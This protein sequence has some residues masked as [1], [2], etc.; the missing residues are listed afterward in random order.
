MIETRGDWMIYKFK[1]PECGKENQL[2]YYYFSGDD[3]L[4]HG[5]MDP[6]ECG[7]DLTEYTLEL[8]RIDMG[9]DYDE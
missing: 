7:K 2:D 8:L 9:V 1:C 3:C 6:C 4:V 5:G